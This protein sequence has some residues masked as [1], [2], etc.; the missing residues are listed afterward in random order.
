[1]TPTKNETCQRCNFV[2]IGID[3]CAFSLDP[4]DSLLSDHPKLFEDHGFSNGVAVIATV[5]TI[6]S[7]QFVGEGGGIIEASTKKKSNE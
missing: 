5:R 6:Q 4:I 2:P 7:H 3:S 1:M